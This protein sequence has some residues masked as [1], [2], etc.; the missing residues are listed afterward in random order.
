MNPSLVMSEADRKALMARRLERRRQ[1][2][3]EHRL[4]KQLQQ[5]QEQLQTSP[6]TV[7]RS[8][9]APGSQSHCQ[10]IR[11]NEAVPLPYQSSYHDQ[12]G[13]E[14][15]GSLQLN[16]LMVPERPP[17]EDRFTD[18]NRLQE[19]LTEQ[20]RFSIHENLPGIHNN[21]TD[22]IKEEEDIMKEE[23][24]D[25]D[26]DQD[27]NMRQ[28]EESNLNH[29][30]EATI[31][32]LRRLLKTSFKFPEF[33]RHYYEEDA[34][35]LEHLFFVFCKAMGQFFSLVPEVRLLEPQLQNVLLKSAVAKAVFI[36]GA[37]QYQVRGL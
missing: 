36:F 28:Y 15:Q 34:D 4:Q 37:H 23:E 13:L 27:A 9:D 16:R 35:V 30:D 11:T 3:L 17:G 26:D 19:K 31:N 7:R 14:N 2:F 8:Q 32:S 20:N 6:N 33:P 10:G 1:K 21:P 25:F 22:V 24:E 5:R 29:E 12:S 18:D